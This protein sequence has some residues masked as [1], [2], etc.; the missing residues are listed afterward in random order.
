MSEVSRQAARRKGGTCR[1]EGLVVGEH[2]PDRL[3]QSASE[4]DLG[5]LGAAL[6]AQAA[7]G[8]LV[9]VAV[10]GVFAGVQSGFEQRP[11]QVLGA[12]LADRAARV[13]GAGLPDP[14]AQAGV[15]AELGWRREAADV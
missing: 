1:S 3:G 7:L 12:V 5:D 8:V 11:A 9:A 13:D 10:V 4:V 6:A 14:G 15:A 2:V